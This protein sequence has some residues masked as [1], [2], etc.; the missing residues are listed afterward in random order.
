MDPSRPALRFFLPGSFCSY[1]EQFPSSFTLCQTRP[2]TVC[3]LFR[4][5]CLSVP[6]SFFF[7]FSKF[8]EFSKVLPCNAERFKLTGKLIPQ[9]AN[10]EA[11]R[12]QGFEFSWASLVIKMESKVLKQDTQ[13]GSSWIAQEPHSPHCSSPQ[14]TQ[15][16]IQLTIIPVELPIPLEL[17]GFPNLKVFHPHPTLNLQV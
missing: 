15:M 17:S 13:I 1:Q 11:C 10:L 6:L 14:H 5:C 16:P 7:P 12:N 9:A 4:F 8:L 3:F 2:P